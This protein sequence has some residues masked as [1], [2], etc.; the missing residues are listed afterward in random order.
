MKV[1]WLGGLVCGVLVLLSSGC[2]T[3]FHSDAQTV[4][5]NAWESEKG[6]AVAA[7]VLVD[8]PSSSYMAMTPLQVAAYPSSF[9]ELTLR[10]DDPCFEAFQYT[11]DTHV[12]PVYYLNILNIYGFGIDY[13]TGSLFDYER[14]VTLPVQRRSDDAACV[15]RPP[16]VAFSP[17]EVSLIP[18]RKP[19]WDLGFSFGSVDP[20]VNE[21]NP[22]FSTTLDLNYF[23]LPR[24]TLGLQTS[25]ADGDVTDYSYGTP[26]RVTQSSTLVT[27]RYFLRDYGGFYVGLASGY[28]SLEVEF[29]PYYFIDKY[30]D[31]TFVFLP[32][33]G[34]ASVEFVPLLLQAGW[35][36]TGRVFVGIDLAAPVSR[37]G[38]GNPRP[39]AET[40]NL[41]EIDN[42]EARRL[43]FKAYREYRQ[44]FEVHV[45]AAISF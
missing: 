22:L 32:A 17:A 18:R 6:E 4:A 15:S 43:A 21:L 35:R 23:L 29:Q 33:G 31:A 40:N 9:R 37:L 26:V 13:L 12:S 20:G 3:L 28:R 14:R 5:V 36:G 25:G 1:N 27:A 34:V 42:P 30:S 11:V 19:K 24:L 8:A 44:P 45:R 41:Q 2:A 7:R 39:I 16:P 10:V 38:L